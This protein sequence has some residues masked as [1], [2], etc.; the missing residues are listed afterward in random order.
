[1][2]NPDSTE[3]QLFTYTSASGY[4]QIP[5]VPEG[6]RTL[7][8]SEKCHFETQVMIAGS[9]YQFDAAF[10]TEMTDNR[11]GKVYAVVEIEGKIWM[12]ENLNYGERIDGIQAQVDNQVVEKFCYEDNES[13]CN[14]YGG[15]YQWNEMMQY[16]HTQGVQGI[17]PDGWH[18]PT[19]D[20]WTALVNY[21]GG[22]NIAGG[23]LKEKGSTHWN[24]PN[25]DATNESGFSALATGCR[26]WDGDGQFVNLGN[27]TSFWS[28][29]EG[30]VDISGA[31]Y[32][33][34][35]YN[36]SQILHYCRDKTMGR[37][38]RCVRD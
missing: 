4:Y 38:V 11:D 10:E 25:T 17:C 20:E 5:A 3:S 7:R 16:S 31:W 6:N 29:T 36:H 21:L 12:A 2:L 30:T 32:R 23:K 27:Y 28:S 14:T 19:D 33:Y 13:N 22:Q 26:L 18:L 8:L 35:E 34:V 37:S 15:L 1:V 24:L 9:D